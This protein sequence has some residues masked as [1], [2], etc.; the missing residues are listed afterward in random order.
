MSETIEIITNKLNSLR[1]KEAM[2]ISGGY[3]CPEYIKNEI[4]FLT[5]NLNKLC[6]HKE[7]VEKVSG[8]TEGL[9]TNNKN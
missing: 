9:T 2:W 8:E 3:E 1:V 4:T 5:D 6:F 7:R